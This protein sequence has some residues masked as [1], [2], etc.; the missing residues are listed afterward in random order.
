[1]SSASALPPGAWVW[2]VAL[3]W[4]TL[5][6][7]AVALFFLLAWRRVRRGQSRTFGEDRMV[8]YAMGA[9]ASGIA[10]GLTMSLINASEPGRGFAR[11]IDGP[12][13]GGFW[14]SLI[15]AASLAGTG[16]WRW[17]R[18]RSAARGDAG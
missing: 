17:V 5:C 15:L 7:L 9:W 3:A 14:L 4:A 12:A 8:G 6:L 11:W 16:A 13:A 18:S 1:M 2:L 10:A